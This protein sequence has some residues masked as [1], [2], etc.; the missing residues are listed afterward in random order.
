M[1]EFIWLYP[2]TPPEKELVFEAEEMIFF[3]EEEL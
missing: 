3:L 2:H 1:L